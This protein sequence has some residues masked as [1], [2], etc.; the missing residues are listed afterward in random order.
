MAA[1]VESNLLVLVYGLPACGKSTLVASLA[2]RDAERA[3][4]DGGSPR[5]ALL[6][7][8]GSDVHAATPLCVCPACT[9]VV[10]I[11]F[12]DYEAALADAATRSDDALAVPPPPR[13]GLAHDD[14]APAAIGTAGGS[15]GRAAVSV[16]SLHAVGGE[17]TGTLEGSGGLLTRAA[18]DDGAPGDGRSLA[19]PVVDSALPPGVV[20]LPPPAHGDV[21]VGNADPA[22]WS[23]GAWHAGRRAALA[24]VAAALGRGSRHDATATARSAA[25]DDS[26]GAPAV[27]GPAAFTTTGAPSAAAA[28]TPTP[29]PAGP[30]PARPVRRIVLC[31][32]TAPLRSM[33]RQLYRLAREGQRVGGGGGCAWFHVSAT[34]A[35]GPCA[36]ESM[37]TSGGDNC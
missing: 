28:V 7:P 25:H 4:L 36:P 32:D 22:P 24:A 23:R 30:C 13:R 27:A 18:V 1:E 12:D 3:G 33:R 9:V 26:A 20:L 17:A 31:E 2:R 15:A 5:T 11:V 34:N 8:V 21:T 16:A 10:P 29:S 19:T 6:A 37:S 14:D 35:C